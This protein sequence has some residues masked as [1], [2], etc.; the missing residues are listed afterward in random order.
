MSCGECFV[1]NAAAPRIETGVDRVLLLGFR[2][3]FV[4]LH[5]FRAILRKQWRKTSGGRQGDN[6]LIACARPIVL[7]C[8]LIV[9][10]FTFFDAGLCSAWM[11]DLFAADFKTIAFQCVLKQ[12]IQKFVRVVIHC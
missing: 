3:I 9:D 4:R 5:S 12:F 7:F 2:A 10:K 11:T 1:V 8:C 6:K